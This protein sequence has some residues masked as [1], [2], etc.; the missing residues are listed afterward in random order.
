MCT[1]AMPTGA[2]TPAQSAA[3]AKGWAKSQT[4]TARNR[5]AAGPQRSGGTTL[6]STGTNQPPAAHSIST[7]AMPSRTGMASAFLTAAIWRSRSSAT[8]DAAAKR[9]AASTLP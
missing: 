9:R 6:S 7:R 2:A 1:M 5:P 4:E 8:R 3:K